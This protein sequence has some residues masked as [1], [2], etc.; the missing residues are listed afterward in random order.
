MTHTSDNT[1]PD[2]KPS[3]KPAEKVNEDSSDY[4]NDKDTAAEF[5]IPEGYVSGEEFEKRV[6]AGLK[7]RLEENGY[8]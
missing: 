1:T 8:L 3:K 6:I 4:L 2:Y 7:R 5:V